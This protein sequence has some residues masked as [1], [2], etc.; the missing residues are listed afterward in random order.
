MDIPNVTPIARAL[1]VSLSRIEQ[2]D[3]A[4]SSFR[5]KDTDTQPTYEN[6]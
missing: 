5:E 4:W 1:S 3:K 2:E 6:G